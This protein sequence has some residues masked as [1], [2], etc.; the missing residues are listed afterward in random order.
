MADDLSGWTSLLLG[1]DAAQQRAAAQ[2]LAQLGEGGAGAAAAMVQAVGSDDETVQNWL[3]SALE[4]LGP[5][6]ETSV[7]ELAILLASAH[8]DVA[9]WAATL[10]G[11]LHA[12]AAPAV[13]ALVKLLADGKHLPA[14]QQ[15][16]K[17]LGQIGAA[18]TS[19]AAALESAAASDDKRLAR[20]AGEALAKVRGA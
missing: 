11:R 14:R 17:A 8:P 10:L 20:L 2:A 18:A 13:A 12:K 7:S 15:A 19:A 4:S 9:Y 16:A 3:T 6:P 5:P 1:D